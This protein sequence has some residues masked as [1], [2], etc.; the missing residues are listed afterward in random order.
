MHRMRT[1][2][3]SVAVDALA[4]C[5][6]ADI[7]DDSVDVPGRQPEIPLTGGRHEGVGVHKLR[8]C[9]LSAELGGEGAAARC[10][11]RRQPKPRQPLPERAHAARRR[12]PITAG[13][14]L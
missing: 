11:H 3:W 12:G 14:T 4:V 5:G 6:G 10:Q 13:H 2:V 9:H 1:R 7:F 8:G